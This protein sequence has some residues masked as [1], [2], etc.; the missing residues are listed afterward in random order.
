MPPCKVG[1]FGA[2]VLCCFVGCAFKLNGCGIEQVLKPV[3]IG[4]ISLLIALWEARIRVG[5]WL[6]RV[7]L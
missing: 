5:R 7:Q 6:L 4:A 3:V 2:P 1:C